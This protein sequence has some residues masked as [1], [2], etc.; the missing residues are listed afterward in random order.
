M[1][2]LAAILAGSG[3]PELLRA[4]LALAAPA[5]AVPLPGGGEVSVRI[6]PDDGHGLAEGAARRAIGS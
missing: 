2:R 3:D 4:A 5:A 1:A 6:D